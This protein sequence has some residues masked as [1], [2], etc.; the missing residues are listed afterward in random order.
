MEKA[1]D[2]EKARLAHLQ[3]EISL[4]MSLVQVH[5]KERRAILNRVRQ[6]KPKGLSE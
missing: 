2:E 5:R 4:H 3:L 1:T 6:R